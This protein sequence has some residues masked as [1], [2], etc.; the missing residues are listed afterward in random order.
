MAEEGVE[1]EAV[2]EVE[3]E[4]E[5]DPVIIQIME[6]ITTINT[7]EIARIMP[8]LPAVPTLLPVAHLNC[9]TRS[10]NTK[11]R[12]GCLDLLSIIYMTKL[13]L[14]FFRKF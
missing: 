9:V 6:I 4:V 2:V 11:K 1:E 12:R 5:V 13:F 7:A 8:L 14:S 3:V 10:V